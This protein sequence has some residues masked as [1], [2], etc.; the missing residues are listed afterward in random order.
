VFHLYLS[1][2]CWLRVIMVLFCVFWAFI[3]EEVD[4]V[5]DSQEI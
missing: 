3:A 5:G 2:I 1:F 4:G